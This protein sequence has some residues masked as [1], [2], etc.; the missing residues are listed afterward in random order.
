[1]HSPKSGL[2]YVVTVPKGYRDESAQNWPLIVF[3]HSLE[4]RGSR[5]SLLL[6][7]PEGE[8][9]GLAGH[10]AARTDLPFVT[11]SPLCPRGTYWFFLHRRLDRLIQEVVKSHDIDPDRVYLTGVSMGGMGT[12]SLAMAHPRRFAAIAPIAGGV[13]APPMVPRY[14]ALRNT[15]VWAFHDAADPSIP[16]RK[17]ARAVER[18]NAVGGSARLTTL[19]TG[20]HYIQSTVFAEGEVFDWFLEHTR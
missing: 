10:A 19:E 3:L 4:E 2:N 7:S 11:L 16:H 14:R 9:I 12:W 13:Y 8:G 17:S 5:I 20:R 18:V 15:A 6:E 1:M